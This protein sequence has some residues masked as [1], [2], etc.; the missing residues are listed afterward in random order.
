MN[1]FL[2]IVL[3]CYGWIGDCITTYPQSG[4][5][6]LYAYG[7]RQSTYTLPESHIE[8]RKILKKIEAHY[9]VSFMYNASL[10]N[11]M[12]PNRFEPPLPS[13]TQQLDRLTKSTTLVYA[14]ISD[15][16]YVIRKRHTRP[17]H[18]APTDDKPIDVQAS[19]ALLLP[20]IENP[21]IDIVIAGVIKDPK[22]EPIP[23]V[24]VL[25]KG[26]AIGT[27][28]DMNGRYTLT[29]TEAQSKGTLVFSFIGFLTQE[30]PINNR[31]QINITLQPD[32]QELQEI[33]VIGYGT[34][35]SESVTGAISSISSEQV[36]ALPV[37]SVESAMQGR[38]PGVS[39]VNNGAPGESPIVRIRGIG[40]ISYASNPLFVVDGFPIQGINTGVLNFPTVGLNNFDAKDIESVSVLKDASASAIYGSRAANGVIMITTKNARNDQGLHVNLDTYYGWQSPWKYLDLLKRDE[41][42]AYGTILRT[43]AGNSLPARYSAL[44]EPI[45]DGATQT[46]NQTE[47]D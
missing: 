35:K 6:T 17:Q 20:E 28:T 36:A 38:V 42:I 3:A 5:N 13:V 34:Q 37:V 16:F 43:N 44:D 2:L 14:K 26:T 40:S 11:V 19:I 39:V 24:N 31:Q 30:L 41:F 4:V 22:G 32:V 9:N 8:L 45:Y 46:Y 27:T 47:T 25:L 23:G 7:E 10:K 12:V 15:N 33:V 21:L 18:T 1:R 29:L